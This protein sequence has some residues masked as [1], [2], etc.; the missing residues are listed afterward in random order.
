MYAIV[1]LSCCVFFLIMVFLLLSQHR[2][3]INMSAA[4]EAELGMIL[5]FFFLSGINP[6]LHG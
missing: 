4:V 2:G 3:Q 6:L 1:F 5:Q